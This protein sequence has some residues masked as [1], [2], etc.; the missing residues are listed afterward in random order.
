MNRFN[1]ME[2]SQVSYLLTSLMTSLNNI[3]TL[4]TKTARLSWD[5]LNVFRRNLVRN[6]GLKSITL[7]YNSYILNWRNKFRRLKP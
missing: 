5:N 1:L 7:K 3:P 2:R 4:I 6:S